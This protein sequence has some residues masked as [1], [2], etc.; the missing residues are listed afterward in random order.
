MRLRLTIWWK[1]ASVGA[2]GSAGSKDH[3][4]R[5]LVQLNA[6]TNRFSLISIWKLS[7]A[8]AMTVKNALHAIPAT[9]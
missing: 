2:A 7:G 9:L 5:F 3:T 1:Q 4:L 8:S 6:H